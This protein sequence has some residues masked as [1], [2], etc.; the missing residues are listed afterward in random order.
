MV[1]CVIK[2]NV[3]KARCKQSSLISVERLA[4][5]TKHTLAETDQEPQTK[6]QFI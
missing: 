5:A 2:K 4:S 6:L 1:V 3:E